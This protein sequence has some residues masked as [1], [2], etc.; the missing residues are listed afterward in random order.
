MNRREALFSLGFGRGFFFGG[1]FV[2]DLDTRRVG[3]QAV[4]VVKKTNGLMEYV[5]DDVIVIHERPPALGRA[6]DSE[7]AD[8]LTPHA[9]FYES[10]DGVNLPLG[11]SAAD[12]QIIR[13]RG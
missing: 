9:V 1:W 8:A 11:I 5:D 4:Y 12:E 13:Q 7:G 6:L 2:L 3:P 10:G